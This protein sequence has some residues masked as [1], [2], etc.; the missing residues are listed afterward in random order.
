MSEES[1]Q[2]YFKLHVIEGFSCN[3]SESK[4]ITSTKLRLE[5]IIASSKKR[6]DGLHIDLEKCFHLSENFSICY[7][8][9]CVSSYTSPQHIERRKRKIK[10]ENSNDVSPKKVIRRSQVVAFDFKINCF[11]CG[12]YC[13]TL[14]P[15]I[16]AGGEEHLYAGLQIVAE[17]RNPS[18]RL[19]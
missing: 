10:L 13:E 12:D 15:K 19:F 4:L 18:S 9:S 8:K 6:E 3:S 11:F 2:C 1:E 16:L 14:I 17:N 5:N 7:H